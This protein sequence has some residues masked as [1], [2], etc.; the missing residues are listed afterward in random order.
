MDAALSAR[1][2]YVATGDAAVDQTSR[3]GLIALTRVLSARTSADLGEPMASSIRRATNSPSTRSS[4]GR[5]SQ[6]GRSPRQRRAL[7]WPPT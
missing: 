1:L 2:A 3:Q 5:S 7:A 4:T 6:A